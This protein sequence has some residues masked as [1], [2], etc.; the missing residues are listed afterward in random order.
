MNRLLIACILSV[1][2]LWGS[3]W[4]IS[5]VE[6]TVSDIIAHIENDQLDAAYTKW[7][8]AATR[9]GALLLHNELDEID[10]LFN[11]LQATDPTSP[12]FA[13]QKAE[14]ITQLQHLPDAEKPSLKNLF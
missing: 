9:F 6:N 1:F 11:R 10:F 13:P 2:L 3:I 8:D 7:N 14:L 12:L 4:S 5:T